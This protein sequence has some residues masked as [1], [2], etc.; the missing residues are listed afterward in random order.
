M[1]LWEGSSH[2]GHLIRKYAQ[3]YPR[4]KRGRLWISKVKKDSCKLSSQKRKKTLQAILQNN[5][6][7]YENKTLS[8]PNSKKKKMEQLILQQR[9]FWEEIV[10]VLA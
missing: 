3:A 9:R 10:F 1:R 2:A 7:T 5:P 8:D 6:L 4:G